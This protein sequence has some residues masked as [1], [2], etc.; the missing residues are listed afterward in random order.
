[1]TRARVRDLGIAIGDLP[2]GPYNAITD[3]PGIL[4]GQVT[5]IYD[6]PRVAR[7]GVT[8]VLPRESDIWKDNAPAAYHALNGTGEMTGV[9]WIE[10]SGMLSSPIALTN[11]AQLG[12]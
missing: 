10:E 2:T 3:V 5:L 11:T 4:V 8:I 6:E 1:M 9:H 7:T 12:G